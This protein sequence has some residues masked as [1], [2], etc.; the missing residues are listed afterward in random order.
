MLKSHSR[1]VL[2][3]RFVR[4]WYT[5]ENK[6]KLTKFGLIVLLNFIF[7]TMIFTTGWVVGGTMM[8]HHLNQ[9]AVDV[10]VANYTTNGGIEWKK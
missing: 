9:K 6:R 2:A 1:L 8:Y 4:S 3:S 10:G 7:G 5:E